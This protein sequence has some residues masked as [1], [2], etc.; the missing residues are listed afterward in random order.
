MVV[1]PLIDITCSCS[2]LPARVRYFVARARY[3]VAYARYL[4]AYA[5]YL[6]AYALI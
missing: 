6:V 2:I 4:V 3:L 1:Y 5:R